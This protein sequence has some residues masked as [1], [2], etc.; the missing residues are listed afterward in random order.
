MSSK[1]G[2]EHAENFLLFVLV[3]G[4]L[5]A[6]VVYAAYLALPFVLFY[7]VPFIVASFVVGVVLRMAGA[8]SEGVAG[9]SKYRVVVMAYAGMLFLVGMVFFQNLERAKILNAK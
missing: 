3:G 7:L 8:P 1:S 6:G 9:I 2:N 4:I 5:L